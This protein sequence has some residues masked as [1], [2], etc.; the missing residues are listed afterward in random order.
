MSLE[1]Q[2]LD[3]CTHIV[4]D[5]PAAVN[6]L[7]L[8]LAS[9]LNKALA[10]VSDSSDV[11]VIRGSGGNFCAGG[12]L[13][14]FARAQAERD[15]LAEFAAEIGAA[16][17]QI[18]ALPIPVIAAVEGYCLAGGF[19]IVQ[20]CDF[21]VARDDAVIGDVHAA[22]S[23]VPGTGGTQR[24]PRWVGRQH[25]LGILL[26]GDRFTGRE[27]AERGLVYRSFPAREF[28]RSVQKL[29]E[30]ILAH[31][32]AALE[33]LKRLVVDLSEVPLHEALARERE[34]FVEHVLGPVGRAGLERFQ[35]RGKDAT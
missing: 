35:A 11:V 29:V 21:A 6:A 24:L 9:A 14:F 4:L 34:A 13:T 15:L 28:E 17:E 7:D 27:A 16:T 32:R 1:F 3:R 25:A 12:D 18:A 5:R 23:Q 19:E 22:F 10:S 26:T 33:P 30:G 31:G 2:Q 20:A 8:E